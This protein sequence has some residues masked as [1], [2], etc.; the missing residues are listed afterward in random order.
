LTPD[1][2]YVPAIDG[3]R[4][5]AILSVMVFHLR[6]R[7][8][9]GGFAGVDIF[10]VI[11]GFVVTASLARQ[12]K[13]GLGPGAFLAKFYA[14]RILRV[15]PALLLMLLT[16]CALTAFFIRG[17]G[18]L[19]AKEVGLP[20]FFGVANM[21]LL[22]FK[23]DYFG[24]DADYHP[25]LHTWTLGIEEQFYFVLPLLL[26]WA[27]RRT[28][29][30]G[31]RRSAAVI[32]GLSFLSLA[33]CAFLSRTS[34]QGAFYLMPAR[35]WELGAG[36][37]LFLTLSRW[38]PAL[39]RSPWTGALLAA[40]SLAGLAASLLFEFVGA[41]PFPGA[42]LPVA[43]SL[44]LLALACA[45]PADLVP[46]I[47]ATRPARMIGLLSYSLYLWHWPVF[48][49]MRWTVG[50]EGISKGLAALALTGAVSAASYLLVERPARASRIL[51]NLRFRTLAAGA[52]A[53]T[54]ASAGAAAILLFNQAAFASRTASPAFWG[55][56]IPAGGCTGSEEKRAFAGGEVRIWKPACAR[57]GPVRRLIVVGDSHAA[58]YAK[59]L[60]RYLA[61]TGTPVILYIK[62]GCGFL[63]FGNPVSRVFSC[64][65]FHAAVT[66][67]LPRIVRRGDV[68]FLPGMRVPH[69]I[70]ARSGLPA[71]EHAASAAERERAAKE[72]FATLDRLADKGVP[73]VL[74][75]PKPVFR[76]VPM[77]CSDWFNRRNIVCAHGPAMA[78]SELLS[79]RQNVARDMAGL[80]R[81]LP[82][83]S[84][85]DPFPILCA[86][87]VCSPYREGKPLYVDD[88]HLSGRGNDLLY[89]HFV[90][91]LHKL[92]SR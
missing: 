85:W 47:L 14:A 37:L 10:F 26:F 48:V 44:C 60:R 70:D 43:A 63:R 13:L 49:L 34:P 51:R 39:Q 15:L 52:A 88:N 59:M 77:R 31:G 79:H 2:R 35:F 45:R 40:A 80:A 5:L 23:D 3:L 25:V 58:G 71:G 90:A 72:A 42:L 50:T 29:S 12:R 17:E 56:E 22:V 92:A 86:S 66:A 87:A 64:G 62:N 11:S 65:R 46:R 84:V 28:G 19:A 18:V 1:S 33:L 74:E 83:V 53:A 41:F 69:L 73:T 16:V 30:D 57:T 76:F 6:P 78:R 38:L 81:A 89:P 61:D 4:A 68:V 82:A 36:A 7:F 32:A 91:H 24:T 55:G 8:L 27:W 75:A 9:P 67:E 54:L 21:A 20:A